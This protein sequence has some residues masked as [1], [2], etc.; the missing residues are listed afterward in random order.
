[1]IK[2]MLPLLALAGCT[3]TVATEVPPAGVETATP[4]EEGACRTDALTDLVGKP[5]TAEV[6]R[7]ALRRSG[8]RT[9][10]RIEPGM[11][12]TMDYRQDRL[13]MDTD[14]EG[15]VTRFHCG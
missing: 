9:M 11:A 3:P 14:A 1:M 13:N 15:N 10:R 12:V 5:G 8:A 7:E 6:A 4:A 2:K